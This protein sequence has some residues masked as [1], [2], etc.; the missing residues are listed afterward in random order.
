MVLGLGFSLGKHKMSN[1]KK[2]TKTH[3]VCPNCNEPSTTIDHLVDIMKDK[4]SCEIRGWYCDICGHQYSFT[5][6]KQLNVTNLI[7]TGNTVSKSHVLLKNKNIGL[8][9]EGS[10]YSDVRITNDEYYYNTHTCPTSYLKQV[11][12]VIDLDKGDCDPHG[13]FKYI[14][15][16]P[17]VED[18]DNF[19]F[20]NV[21]QLNSFQDKKE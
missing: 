16:I 13:I 19:N 9:V 20:H 18:T 5:V 21:F 17:Y 1:T 14:T 3:I 10:K 2:I 15:T 6:D 11:V 8:V 4:P 12:R 7:L